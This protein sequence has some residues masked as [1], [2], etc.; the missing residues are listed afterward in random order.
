MIPKELLKK[1]LL[2]FYTGITRSA[3]DILKKQ[4]NNIS[5]STKKRSMLGEMVRLAHKLKADLQENRLDTFGDILHQNW[6]I[7]KELTEDISNTQ[8]DK[9]YDTALKNGATG[10][11]LLGAGGGGFLLFFAPKEKHSNIIL[12]LKQLEPVPFNFD[13][14]GSKIIF[15]H[16]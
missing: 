8:I 14:E 13:T 7:K 15:V 1:N 11:K 9:W 16:Q 12:A 3:S 6:I 2:L 4:V 10:G 5:I